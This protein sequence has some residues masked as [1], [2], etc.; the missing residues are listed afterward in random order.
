[1]PCPGQCL[2]VG[3]DGS[4]RTTKIAV[5]LKNAVIPVWPHECNLA[6]VHAYAKDLDEFDSGNF[7]EAQVKR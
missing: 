4:I 1:V 2:H 5:S 6:K 3:M 7:P